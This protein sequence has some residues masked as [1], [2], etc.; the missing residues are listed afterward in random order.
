MKAYVTNM[1]GTT[2]IKSKKE[3]VWNFV[4]DYILDILYVYNGTISY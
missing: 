2:N 1:Y 4:L 3:T